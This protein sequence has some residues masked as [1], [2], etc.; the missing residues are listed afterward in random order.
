MCKKYSVYIF[1]AVIFYNAKQFKI[2]SLTLLELRG[3]YGWSKLN[4]CTDFPVAKEVVKDNVERIKY[5]K[6]SHEE[7]VKKYERPSVPVVV[8]GAQ[9]NWRA[10]YKWNLEVKREVLYLM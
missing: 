8:V 10:A 5:K 2:C 7:F 3:E 6:T 1:F 4:Y 9:E